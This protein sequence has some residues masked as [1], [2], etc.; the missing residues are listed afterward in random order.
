[1]KNLQEKAL[2]YTWT[3]HCT[4]NVCI[5]TAI[6]AKKLIKGRTG[7]YPINDTEACNQAKQRLLV[8]LPEK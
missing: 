5:S 3:E 7:P 6:L 4:G 1:M 2:M 8:Y